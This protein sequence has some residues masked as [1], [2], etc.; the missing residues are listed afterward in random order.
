MIQHIWN[1]FEANCSEYDGLNHPS[2][3]NK[4]CDEA[5]GEYCGAP[6]CNDWPNSSTACCGSK[7]ANET[8][9]GEESQMA[10]CTLSKFRQRIS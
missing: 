9:C 1:T 10:P 3:P 2:M 8:I 7:I 6:N 4:C 5:C